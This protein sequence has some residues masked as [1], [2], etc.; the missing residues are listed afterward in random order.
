M[1]KLECKLQSVT[2]NKQTK[3]GHRHHET[4]RLAIHALKK[5]LGDNHKQDERIKPR[6]NYHLEF[7]HEGSLKNQSSFCSN[8]RSTVVGDYICTV[9]AGLFNLGR[10]AHIR[11]NHSQR[12]RNCRHGSCSFAPCRLSLHSRNSVLCKRNLAGWCTKLSYCL[13]MVCQT[14]PNFPRSS[15]SR[16][17]ERIVCKLEGYPL[18][19][20]VPFL[21]WTSFVDAVAEMLDWGLIILASICTKALSKG[22]VHA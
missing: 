6:K 16:A 13:R 21:A 11:C 8:L 1:V 10:A 17:L 3:Q 5:S 15:L 14:L 2:L 20:A 19:G 22:L 4:S 9:I 7:D 18:D 12:G